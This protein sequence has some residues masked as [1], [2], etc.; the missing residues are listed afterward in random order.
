M[1]IYLI[2]Y[3]GS[4]KS[5]LGKILAQEQDMNFIDFDDFLEEKE[6]K[7]IS[8][9]FNEQGEIY[10]RKKEALYLQELL[11]GYDNSVISLGG[12]T[13]CYGD[14]MQRI[15]EAEGTSVYINVPVKELAS[16]LWSQREHRP[17]LKHQDTPEKLEEFVRKHLFE[18]SFYY[19][20]AVVKIMVKEQGVDELI[21]ALK[22]KLF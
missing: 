2:G 5:T 15:N 16:R 8:E 22:T 21:K 12:G 11:Q 6:G 7:S 10:F 19:N 4:G 1:K 18:R 17:V 3:M 13:P 9:I 20:Q 14:A